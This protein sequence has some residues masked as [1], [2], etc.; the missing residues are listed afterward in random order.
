M[1]IFLLCVIIAYALGIGFLLGSE[2]MRYSIKHP[3]EH[4]EV[5]DEK[6]PPAMRFLV[7]IVSPILAVV[8]GLYMFFCGTEE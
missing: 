8:W 6:I 5:L 3:A 7:V 4:F 2:A 1:N